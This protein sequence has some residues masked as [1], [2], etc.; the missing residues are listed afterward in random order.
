MKTYSDVE[1]YLR[2]FLNLDTNLELNEELHAVTVLSRRT[3]PQ[4]YLGEEA[5]W[6]P[7]YQDK[8]VI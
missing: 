5:W 6:A 2:A 7:W 8:L 3:E 4:L 1:V